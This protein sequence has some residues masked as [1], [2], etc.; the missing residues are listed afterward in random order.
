MG[1]SLVAFSPHILF[2]T[3]NFPPE[4]NAPASRTFDHCSEWVREGYRITIVTSNPNFP[5]GR[6]HAGHRNRLWQSETIAGMRVIRVWTYMA[7]NV[8]FAK[9]VVD[10]L[11]Y[12]ITAT[13]AG[14]FVRKVDLVVGTSP[15]LFVTCS[16]MI[17][18]WAKRVPFVFEL[19]DLWPESIKTVGVMKHGR[20]IELL[21]RLE[22]F[23]YRRAALVVA[24][25]HSFKANLVRRGIAPDKI[26][27]IT[28]GADLQ[29]F[30][31]APYPRELAHSLGVEGHFVAGYIGTHGLAQGLTTLLDAAELVRAKPDGKD[32]V[33]L[34]IGQ[35]AQ[36]EALRQDAERRG[37][38]NVRFLD[39]VPKEAVAEY[40]RLLDV[41]IIHLRR[42][43]LFE[44]VIPSKT[45]EAMAV[46]T[47]I[48]HG[49]RGE[50]AEI[51]R[52]SAS[53]RVFEPEDAAALADLVLMM[54]H[55][56]ALRAEFSR[57]GP[58]AASEYDRRNLAH[59]MLRELD[60]LLGESSRQQTGCEEAP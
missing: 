30:A 17:L 48:L 59:A 22:L 9:R 1:P 24:V 57:N 41:A 36:R 5:E 55:E 14:L 56:P 47:P 4:V 52:R 3:D 18:G 60:K 39:P 10:F 13:V 25:T 37:L 7:P 43:D 38:S 23:L 15:H 46:G 40:W 45:F 53:G 6:L 12:M 8:G 29:R 51:I 49:V 44:T 16:A 35:G 54:K 26:R 2:L 20:V 58:A 31:P 19:R 33:F 42:H 28:N 11:T 50:S 34:M 21:E 27:V 32:V